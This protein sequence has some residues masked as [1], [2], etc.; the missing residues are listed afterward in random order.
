MNLPLSRIVALLLIG[1][2]SPVSAQPAPR[3]AAIVTAL[4]ACRTESDAAK[5]LACYDAAAARL[6]T[7]TENREVVVLDRA[8]IQETRRS[9]FGFSLPRIALFG[10]GG[11]TKAEENIKREDITELQTTINRVRELGNGQYQLVL[12]EGG[13]WQSTEAWAGARLPAKGAKILIR[14]A[15]LGSYFL[16]VEGGRAVRGMRVG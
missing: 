4:T 3:P 7:A 8:A 12:T 14:R 15:T 6:A 11:G 13:T 2:M 5:R 9:L 16:K 10:G 1:M